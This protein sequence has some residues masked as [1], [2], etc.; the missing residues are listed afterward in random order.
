MA[1]LMVAFL[2]VRLPPRKS[3]IRLDGW[4]LPPNPTVDRARRPY[5]AAESQPL[6]WSA[7]R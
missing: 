7:A 3:A 5:E 2:M 6:D 1:F 4:I